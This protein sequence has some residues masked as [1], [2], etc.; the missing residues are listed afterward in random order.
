MTSLFSMSK[1]AIELSDIDLLI[2]QKRI[3]DALHLTNEYIK[4]NPD[5][6]DNARKRINIIF[7]LRSDYKKKADEL[8]T[9]L[10]EEPLNDKKKL[11]I[12]GE[13]ESMEANPNKEEKEFISKIKV[14]AQFT[15]FRAL[16]EQILEEAT[17][18][19]EEE[20]YSEA[21]NK[22][23]EGFVLYYDDFF[24]KGFD[25]SLVKETIES[26]HQI[27]TS[28]N[29]YSSLQID[30][31][32][33]VE[34]FN[35]ALKESNIPQ[36]VELY[37]QL[38]LVLEDF[39]AL[40]NS[41][42]I[43]GNNFKNLTET[44]QSE[45]PELTDA[46]FLPFAYRLLLGRNNEEEADIVKTM[47]TQWV[48]VYDYTLTNFAELL[49]SLTNSL[50]KNSQQK[51]VS[52]IIENKSSLDNQIDAINTSIALV[53]NFLQ[54][55]ELLQETTTTVKI[56]PFDKFNTKL[57]FATTL[58]DSTTHYLDAIINYNEQTKTIASYPIPESPAS[59]LQN[60]EKDYSNFLF[61]EALLGE[62]AEQ[63]L[64]AIIASI[65]EEKSN[66]DLYVYEENQ[67]DKNLGPTLTSY[68]NTLIKNLT[69]ISDKNIDLALQNLE[70]ISSFTEAGSNSIKINYQVPFEQAIPLINEER[71]S[72]KQSNPLQ[73]QD[74]LEYLLETIDDDILVLQ[75]ELTYLQSIPNNTDIAINNSTTYRNNSQNITKTITYLQ[76]LKT[77]TEDYLTLAQQRIRL[78]QQAKN[79][80]ELRLREAQKNLDNANFTASRE[81]LQKARTKYNESLDYQYS[82]SLLQNSD[83]LIED[84]GNQIAYAE[85]QIIVAKVRGLI[86]ESRK[87]YYNS[88][89]L[90]A[91]T[92]I[93]QA[94]SQWA[95]TNVEENPEIVSL[96]ALISNALSLTT[97]RSIP[98]TDPLYPEMSQ[99]LNIAYKHYETAEN[100]LD[101]NQR[102]LAL[103]ELE[104]A[105]NKIRDIQVLY[106]FHQK[107]S[108]LA[109]Q[110]DKL[111][112]PVAFEEQFTL[113]F[114]QA[115]TDYKDSDTMT[116]AYIDLLDL[117]EINPNYPGLERFIYTVELDLGIILPP[118]DYTSL[119]KSE[120]LTREAQSLYDTDSR[121]EINLT[122]ARNLL[123]EAIEL[124]PEN[125]AALILLDRIN[126][127][128]GGGAV[129]VLSSEAEGLY[130]KAVLE[131]SH[132]NTITAASLLEQLLQIPGSK[133]SAKVIDLKKRVDSLL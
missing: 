72:T 9:V 20:N 71:D 79:E 103:E 22:L 123:A 78:A 130:Q 83:Q 4:E 61:N 58:L 25:D 120:N 2:E 63:E 57:A 85:N 101:N 127:S 18:L 26:I 19:L 112:D 116:R 84:I 75:E 70:T 67:S 91:E 90:Q 76:G 107:A 114:E 81:A 11:D 45:N 133:N 49:S 60:R 95:I 77:D 30:I 27:Q 125:T 47:D 65:N 115:K 28:Y 5:D 97:G 24:E 51:T 59:T 132:G 86:T 99:T 3:N 104:L 23:A 118:P 96:K 108:L 55:Y 68:Q 36:A 50:N 52:Y 1:P 94:E 111:I 128:L 102:T 126:T 13:L 7:E 88:N 124:N 82:D 42:F 87:N 41:S 40:R 89:F 119:A 38:T 14:S 110:I 129:I 131:L 37:P 44:L 64:Q 100:Y 109:L 34:K 48:S 33:I 8:V 17:V 10:V 43:A 122:N 105:R 62:T 32:N 46:F 74:D 106:P 53:E 35:N 69:N 56:N 93:L 16:Y 31:K 15:Y 73:A 12:I 54:Q 117:Y 121:N 39:A 92:L 98:S 6:F 80:A 113:K 66:Y 21:V 29:E